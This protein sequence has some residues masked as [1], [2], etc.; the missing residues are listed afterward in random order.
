MKTL[1]LIT[2]TMTAT[3]AIAGLSGTTAS[4]AVINPSPTVVGN[5]NGTVSTI[6]ITGAPGNDNV[7]TV[8]NPNVQINGKN[9]T[10]L[11]PID[12]VFT[13]TNSTLVSEYLVAEG[14]TNSTGQTWA[15]YKIELG[16]GSGGSF[17]ASPAGDGLDFDAPTF[18]PL[19]TAGTSF[20]TLATGQD[21]LLFTSGTGVANGNPLSLQFSI[22]VPDG[23]A[24][25]TFTLRQTPLNASMVPEPTGVALLGLGAGALLLCRRRRREATN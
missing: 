17:V 8:G 11:G 9:F 23:L 20:T 5:G 16:F 3:A 21:T 1:K 18:D 2:A 24:G 6:V 12:I 15:G 25:N 14:V 4:A 22:D 13:T 7:T 19:P 10:A